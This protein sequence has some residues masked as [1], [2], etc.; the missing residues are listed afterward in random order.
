MDVS[1]YGDGG[2]K[3]EE[4]VSEI[5]DD[6]FISDEHESSLSTTTEDPVLPSIQDEIDMLQRSSANGGE[7]GERILC[8]I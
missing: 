8:L 2:D 7:R 4:Y 3:V 6:I 5:D 1:I